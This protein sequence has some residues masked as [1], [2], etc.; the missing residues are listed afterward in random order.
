MDRIQLF[1]AGKGHPLLQALKKLLQL[2][3]GR[4]LN[5]VLL[6]FEVIER[7]GHF[8]RKTAVERAAEES[9]GFGA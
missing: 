7:I 8:S 1:A 9:G 5:D 2:F 4:I 3:V 6:D